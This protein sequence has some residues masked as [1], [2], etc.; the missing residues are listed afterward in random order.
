MAGWL[1]KRVRNAEIFRK[2]FSVCG[3]VLHENTQ[4]TT[5]KR[6]FEWPLRD[7]QV[8]KHNWEKGM[9]CR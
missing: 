2:V 7:D 4:Q 8:H 9:L 1:A 5:E 6:A 3:W